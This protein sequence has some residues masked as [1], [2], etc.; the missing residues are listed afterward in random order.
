MPS[1]YKRQNHQ[2][3]SKLMDWALV[4]QLEHGNATDFQGIKAFSIFAFFAARCDTYHVQICLDVV[5][6]QEIWLHPPL[7]P[8]CVS[9]LRSDVRFVWWY[10]SIVSDRVTYMRHTIFC[11]LNS[12]PCH[13]R[14][15]NIHLFALRIWMYDLTSNR[16]CSW[17]WFGTGRPWRPR[18][19]APP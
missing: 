17:I 2:F 8:Q 6:R 12:L 10:N 16:F 9:F 14:S 1:I 4:T 3:L 19:K 7:G 15:V 11:G 13:I 5:D 18:R